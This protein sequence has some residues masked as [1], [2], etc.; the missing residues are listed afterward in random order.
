MRLVDITNSYPHLVAQQ[1]ENTDAE[2]VKVYTLGAITIVY[3]KAPTHDELLFTS[4]SRNIKNAEIA[5]A[6]KTLCDVEFKDVDVI[7]GERL[8]EISLPKTA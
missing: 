1:L 6:L 4:E 8:A 2:Y 7:R 5:F 3:T